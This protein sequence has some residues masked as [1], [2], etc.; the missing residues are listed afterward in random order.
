MQSRGD[1]AS[2][3]VAVH[4]PGIAA[5]CADALR[6]AAAR[7]NAAGSGDAARAANAAL[8]KVVLLGKV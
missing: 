6:V 2:Q 7:A 8:A 5:T 3:D 4:L 1:A